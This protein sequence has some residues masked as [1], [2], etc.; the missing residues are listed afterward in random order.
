MDGYDLVVKIDNLPFSYVA[1]PTFENFTDGIRK[2][3]NNLIHAKVSQ[4]SIAIIC[5]IIII[6]HNI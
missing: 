2:Q 4:L 3:V 1:D 5:F 6:I